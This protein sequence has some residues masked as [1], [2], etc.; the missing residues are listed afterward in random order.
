MFLLRFILSSLLISYAVAIQD[1]CLGN[2]F[3]CFLTSDN[4]VYCAGSNNVGQLGLPS[5][6]KSIGSSLADFPLKPVKLSGVSQIR[7]GNSSVC[8]LL[9]NK[10]S[11]YCWGQAGMTGNGLNVN[12]FDPST[13]VPL[14]GLSV[15]DFGVGTNAACALLSDHSVHCWGNN[16]QY[17]TVGYGNTNAY[18]TPGPPVNISS[19]PAEYAIGLSVGAYGSIVLTNMNNVIAW[20]LNTYG[21]LGIGTYQTVGPNPG[22]FP[23]TPS[24]VAN[25]LARVPIKVIAGYSTNC[26]I[27]NDNYYACAGRG[28][29]GEIDYGSTSNSGDF[30][31]LHVTKVS[32][33]T[34]ANQRCCLIPVTNPGITPYPLIDQ[35][36]CVGTNS[37]YQLGFSPPGGIYGTLAINSAPNTVNLADTV[38]MASGPTSFTSNCV[39][40]Y[41]LGS[42]YAQSFCFGGQSSGELAL[43]TNASAVSL[44]NDPYANRVRVVCGDGIVQL[45]EGEECDIDTGESALQLL[46]GNNPRCSSYCQ[47]VC[48]GPQPNPSAICQNGQWTV[49]SNLSIS[50]SNS[51]YTNV[52][53]IILGNFLLPNT[54]TLTISENTNISSWLCDLEWHITD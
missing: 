44:T 8:A 21:G 34:C 30:T 16:D 52:S 53:I 4:L 13:T 33:V 26:V 42:S 25:P 45:S 14:S 54:T 31:L 5:S 9:A 37:I 3:T 28:N 6:I 12:V 17:G 10:K 22:D 23:P 24:T 47:L 18:L 38:Q 41:P 2:G 29:S 7:C 46:E 43:A 11:L 51:D 39:L 32:N 35:V 48:Q 36:A 40:A 19:N 27:Y 15:S 49:V 50:G 20:G 1:V